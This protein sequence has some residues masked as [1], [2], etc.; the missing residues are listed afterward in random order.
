M[1]VLALF[2]IPKCD[3]R[4]RCNCKVS[5]VWYLSCLMT[6][7]TKDVRPAKTQI[8]L[9]IRPIWSE[10]SLCTQWVAKDPSFLHANSKDSDQT[11][12]TPRLI[13][14]F[15]GRTVILLVLPWG[16]SFLCSGCCN[17]HQGVWHL[18]GTWRWGYGPVSQYDI[19]WQNRC[20]CYQGTQ[21]ILNTCMCGVQTCIIWALSW[22]NLLPTKCRSAFASAPSDLQLCWSLT[23]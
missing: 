1:S 20:L 12:R 13:W 3:D 6:K 7:P 2:C 19:T 14:V 5:S 16:C 9:D 21:C 17:G 15:A 4:K 11:G 23:R 18:L 22:E 8:S 10:S